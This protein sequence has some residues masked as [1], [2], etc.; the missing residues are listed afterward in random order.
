MNKKKIGKD[1]EMEALE[2]L[3]KE[4]DSVEWLSENKHSPFD[5]KCIKGDKVY[6]GEAKS[7]KYGK[8]PTLTI[9]QISANFVIVKTKEGTKIIWEKDFK[10]N[11]YIQNNKTKS[12]TVKNSTWESLSML[13]LET[14]FKS[15]DNLLKYLVSNYK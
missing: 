5:F 9:N 15:L 7:L 4:F 12:I 1:F 14:K 2:I 13:K 11:I 8:K 10:D 6:F 3:K